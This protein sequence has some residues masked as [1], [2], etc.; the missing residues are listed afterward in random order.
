[1]LVGY[2][3]NNLVVYVRA[4]NDA[5]N[6]NFKKEMLDILREW[7]ASEAI[8]K[9]SLKVKIKTKYCIMYNTMHNVYIYLIHS[10][11]RTV[12]DVKRWQ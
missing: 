9:Q 8:T 3:K 12:Q 10:S 1:M 11:I 4:S 2:G 6:S 5:D 7:G